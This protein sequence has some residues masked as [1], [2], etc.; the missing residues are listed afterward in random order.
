MEDPETVKKHIAEKIQK[1]M[2]DKE[3]LVEFKKAGA[4][5]TESGYTSDLGESR[6]T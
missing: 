4:T 5:R 6:A 2:V 3:T 1:M